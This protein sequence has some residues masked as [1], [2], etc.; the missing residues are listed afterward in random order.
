[1]EFHVP[2]FQFSDSGNFSHAPQETRHAH[3]MACDHLKTG[4]LEKWLVYNHAR[5]LWLLGHPEN[6]SSGLR[7]PARLR[8]P[9]PPAP[10]PA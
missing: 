7:R 1:M 8:R 3:F 5:N 4:K 6:C 10:T 9:P 2:V